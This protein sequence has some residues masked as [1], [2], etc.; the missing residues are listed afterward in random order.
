[1]DGEPVVR[2]E[3][4]GDPSFGQVAGGNIVHGLDPARLA[5]ILERLLDHQQQLGLRLSALE[6]LHNDAQLATALAAQ[7]DDKRHGYEQSI[8]VNAFDG[9]RDQIADVAR[10]QRWQGWAIVAV[11]VVLAIVAFFGWQ[12]V[13]GVVML[14]GGA[15]AARLGR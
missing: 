1:M 9:V 11:V 15:L 4:A 8:L 14:A 6:R 2:V 7:E 5:T 12:A 3:Q 10:W 13:A